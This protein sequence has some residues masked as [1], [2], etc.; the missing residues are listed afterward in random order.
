MKAKLNIKLIP[1][2]FALVANTSAVANDLS[3]QA[4]MQQKMVKGIYQLTDGALSMCSK[5]DAI[6]FKETLTLFKNSYPKVMKLVSSSPY[7]ELAKSDVYKRLKIE[8]DIAALSQQCLFKQKMLTTIMTTE[9]G[10]LTMAKALHTLQS[11]N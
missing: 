2:F 1:L 10:K 11:N 9:E 6:V 8:S 7:I 4:Q 5:E 3:K